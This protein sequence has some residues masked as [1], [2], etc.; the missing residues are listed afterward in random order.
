MIDAMKWLPIALILAASPALAVARFDSDWSVSAKSRARLIADNKGAALQIA[1][2]PGAITYWRDPGEAGVPPTFDFSGSTNLARAEVDF[3]APQR[4]A[5]PDGS[6]AFGYRDGVIL[7][8]RATPTD[9][10]QPVR[11]V[12]KVDYA[13][14]E[15]ICL[16]AQAKAEI[17]VEA[18]ASSPFAEDLTRARA[19]VPAKVSAQSLG[20]TV[21]ARSAKSWRLCLAQAPRDLFVEAPEGFWIQPTAEADRKCYALVEQQAPEGGK[22]PIG[23]RVT[24]ETDEGSRETQVSLGG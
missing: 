11:L 18:G 22:P 23:L 12:A 7:P 5:E 4:I 9:P 3:P 20:A 24:V 15:K 14:C 13:V 16:P 10:S 2:G 8:I 17:A 21:T 6:V 19:S 1:L